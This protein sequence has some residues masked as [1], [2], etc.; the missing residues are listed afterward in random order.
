MKSFVKV[1]FTA[2]LSRKKRALLIDFGQD[3]NLIGNQSL[4]PE[5]DQILNH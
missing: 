3:G 4:K 1:V 2:I 5:S